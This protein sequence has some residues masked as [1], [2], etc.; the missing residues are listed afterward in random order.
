MLPRLAIARVTALFCCVDWLEQARLPRHR[1]ALARRARRQVAK[2][3]R[4]VGARAG[5]DSPGGRARP[6]QVRRAGGGRNP[7]PA[8]REFVRV[9]PGPRADRWRHGY[10]PVGGKAGNRHAPALAPSFAPGS[11]PPSRWP[12]Y[13]STRLYVGPTRRVAS[14]APSSPRRRS[15]S[16]TR[17]TAASSPCAIA[18]TELSWSVFYALTVVGQSWPGTEAPALEQR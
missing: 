7:R 10:Q 9:L 4:G 13:P 8:A 6:A 5:H 3:V 17:T 12:A 16:A 15:R 11:L 2:C 18:A 1:R 14:P